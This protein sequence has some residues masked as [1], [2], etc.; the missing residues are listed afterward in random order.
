MELTSINVLGIFNKEHLDH[1]YY[2][3]GTGAFYKLEKL[4]PD[5]V[6]QLLRSLGKTDGYIISDGGGTNNK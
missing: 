2:Q 4:S 5:E 3:N 6:V 1:I